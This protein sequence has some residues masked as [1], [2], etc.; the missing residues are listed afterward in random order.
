MYP[1]FGAINRR[2]LVDN[3]R[4]RVANKVFALQIGQRKVI[5]SHVGLSAVS[6]IAAHS[7]ECPIWEMVC[8]AVL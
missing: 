5:F 4:R 3:S 1:M 6:A 2:R 8:S 7:G